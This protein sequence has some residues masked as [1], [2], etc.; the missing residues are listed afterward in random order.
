MTVVSHQKPGHG[1]ELAYR[2][3]G[4]QLADIDD[5]G[6]QCHRSGAQYQVVGDKRVI[7]V[8]Y[9]NRS[10]RLTLP[11]VAVSL[12]DSQEEVPLAD[13]ILLV[14]Y[15]LQAKGTP[16]TGRVVSYKELPGGSNYFPNFSQRVIQPILKY[17]GPEP[18][19]LRIVAAA[20]GGYPAD[21][22]DVAVTI[23]AFSRVPVT[24]VLWRGD[25]EFPP[26]GNMLFDSS[27]SDY[28]STED[29]NVLGEAIARRLIN[30]LKAAGDNS[31]SE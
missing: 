14:H 31:L 29:V 5:L 19:R 28:L 20:L 12:K 18:E 10:Y 1:Y 11:G 8:E 24:M 16:L 15:L 2:L 4:E 23:N 13:K 30:Q 25:E 9:L 17:F 22:G 6:P 26:E 27:V 7:T 3:A 21:Y